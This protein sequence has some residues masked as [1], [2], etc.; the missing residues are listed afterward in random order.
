[1]RWAATGTPDRLREPWRPPPACHRQTSRPRGRP[2][3]G[4]RAGVDV[5]ALSATGARAVVVTPAHQAPT[6]VVLTPERRQALVAWASEAD[7]VIIE[8]EYDNEFRYDRQPVGSPGGPRS[9]P[10]GVDRHRQQDPRPHPPAGLGR[11]PIVAHRG[12]RAGEADRRPW[13]TRAGPAGAGDADRVRALRPPPPAHARP[14]RRATGRARGGARRACAGPDADRARRRL[15]RCRPPAGRA[16]GASGRSSPP[17]WSV[18][19][20]SPG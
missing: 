4:G 19:S 2:G 15:P 20:V 9:G 5:A 17:G 3:R 11:L 14:L 8:D 6:G 7:A 16:P 12:G 18:R 13:L 1:M 10:G